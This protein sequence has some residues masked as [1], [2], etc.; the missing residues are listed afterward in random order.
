[1]QAIVS[2]D[3]SFSFVHPESDNGDDSKSISAATYWFG[4]TSRERLDLR[5]Q[6]SPL[7]HVGKDTPPTLF[8]NSSVKRM[9]AGRDDFQEI[10]TRNAVYSEVYTFEDAPHSFCLFDPWFDPT[11]KKISSFLNKVL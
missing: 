6:A 4:Y 8:L 2:L 9:H 10:L 11:V 1:M 7:T 3:G 5:I